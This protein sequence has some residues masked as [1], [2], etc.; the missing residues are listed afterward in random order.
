MMIIDKEEYGMNREKEEKREK[1]N[2]NNWIWTDNE[3][4]SEGA[5][6]LSEVLKSNNTL[7]ELNLMSDDNW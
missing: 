2:D 4:E 5:R 1:W 3:I 6:M 7:T